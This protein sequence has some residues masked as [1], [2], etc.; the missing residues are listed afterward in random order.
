MGPSARKVGEPVSG[1]LQ[2]RANSVS[3][4]DEISDM[5]PAFWLC[6]SAGWVGS[7]NGQ[8]PLP[9]FLSGRKLSPSSHL[10]ARRFSF[11]QYAT[12]AFQVATPVLKLRGSESE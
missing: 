6:G 1:D 11:S 9:T 3:Q 4:V 10:Q 5:V 2:G 7:E 12:G 8:W